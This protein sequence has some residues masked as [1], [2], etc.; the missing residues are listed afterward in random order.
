MGTG[1]EITRATPDDSAELAAIH[2]TARR[3]AMPYLPALHSDQEIAE[4]FIGRV[5]EGPPEAFWVARCG[6][7][8]LGYPR[9]SFATA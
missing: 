8:I 5:T 6:Q 3:D 7:L 2:I 4:W 9:G 1:N